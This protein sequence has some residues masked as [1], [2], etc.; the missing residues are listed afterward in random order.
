MLNV[1]Q[2]AYHKIVRGLGEFRW[3]RCFWQFHI[4]CLGSLSTSL[5]FY[6]WSHLEFF[7]LIASTENCDDLHNFVGNQLITYF[8]ACFLIYVGDWQ[9]A[10]KPTMSVRHAKNF[11]FIFLYKSV[12]LPWICEVVTHRTYLGGMPLSILLVS[13]IWRAEKKYERITVFWDLQNIF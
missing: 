4:F 5:R 7:L 11:N 6:C 12:S 10:E 3:L 8:S 2:A 1:I 9:Q 13:N